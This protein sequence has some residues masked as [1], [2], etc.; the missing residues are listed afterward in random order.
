NDH[1]VTFLKLTSITSLDARPPKFVLCDQFRI[2]RLSS[3]YKRGCT[4]EYVNNVGIE[5]VDLAHPGL[6]ASAGVNHVVLSIRTIFE[7]VSFTE[8][9]GNGLAV[10]KC[11]R[12]GLLI[13]QSSRAGHC[14]LFILLCGRCTRYA[15]P[16]NNLAVDHDR[17]TA[18]QRSEIWKSDHSCA[19]IF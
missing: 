9:I 1:N 12:R 2:D 16:T 13:R 4:A 15:N 5:L 18:L 8:C 7:N 10:E 11:D 6:F 17:D 19:P 3:G 14:E